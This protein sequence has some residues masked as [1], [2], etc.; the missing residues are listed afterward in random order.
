MKN[1]LML[2]SLGGGQLVDE[3]NVFK[4]VVRRLDVYTEEEVEAIAQAMVDSGAVQGD[5][6]TIKLAFSS[7]TYYI[8]GIEET[9]TYPKFILNNGALSTEEHSLSLDNKLNQTAII[10]GNTAFNINYL[11]QSQNISFALLENSFKIFTDSMSSIHLN[12]SIE[13]TPRITLTRLDNNAMIWLYATGTEATYGF[14]N[15][16]ED[17]PTYELSNRFFTDADVGKEVAFKLDK[18][19]IDYTS[20]QASEP[21]PWP[22]N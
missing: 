10:Y 2:R 20:G 6:E 16:N 8:G 17:D 5:L 14:G 18:Y 13:V 7:P 22:E 15:S 3:K 1:E 21:I 12:G 11:H 19:Y 9:C 4:G